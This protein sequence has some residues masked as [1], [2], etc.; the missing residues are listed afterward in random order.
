[1]I[2]A[3]CETVAVHRLAASFA[4]VALLSGCHGQP[5]AEPATPPAP[6]RTPLAS[7]DAN[8]ILTVDPPT[9]F[10]LDRTPLTVTGSAQ[11]KIESFLC[12][13]G[14]AEDA[15]WT[16]AWTYVRAKGDGNES[17]MR[18]PDALGRLRVVYTKAPPP[19]GV[20]LAWMPA[21]GDDPAAAT[22]AALAAI[23]ALHLD[24]VSDGEGG[25]G[26]VV[27]EL[28]CPRAAHMAAGTTTVPSMPSTPA[29]VAV[30]SENGLPA[31]AVTLGEIS[32]LPHARSEIN[33]AGK[34]I[35][36]SRPFTI[37]FK[38]RST[39][40]KD[41]GKCIVMLLAEADLKGCSA[42]SYAQKAGAPVHAVVENTES[43]AIDVV[44]WA[45]Q[46]K[47]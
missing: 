15:C 31:G 27:L 37:G 6:V 19:P 5:A 3:L 45:Q 34:R 23:R 13:S 7:C 29:T 14:E 36:P 46:A 10:V 9:G 2:R 33:D 11:T 1:V 44:V 26:T 30:A 43:Y 32:V 47:L 17:V 24:A 8:S 4:I 21:K 16:R 35:D 38:V 42:G 12:A 41:D 18:D 22:A 39:I 25:P 40:E 28:H 20:R